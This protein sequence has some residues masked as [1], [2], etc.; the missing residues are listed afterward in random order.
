MTDLT[1]RDATKHIIPV[2]QRIILPYPCSHSSA[3]AEE[4]PDFFGKQ[5]HEHSNG[6]RWLHVELMMDTNHSYQ[7]MLLLFSMLELSQD[8]FILTLNLLLLSILLV[9]KLNQKHDNHQQHPAKA[10]LQV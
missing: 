6:E 8:R 5:Y 3:T 2:E 1:K 10:T 7:Q 9:W 4:D